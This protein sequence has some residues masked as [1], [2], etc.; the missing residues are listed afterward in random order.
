[1][2]RTQKFIIFFLVVTL[3]ANTLILSADSG[4][5]TG[6]NSPKRNLNIINVSGSEPE[7]LDPQIATSEAAIN[8]TSRI[9]EGLMKRSGKAIIPGIASRY[10][11]SEDGL[12]YTF[13]LRDAVW[14]DGK[15]V[16]AND[17]AYGWQRALDPKTVS[18]Y[19]FLMYY[20]KN[21]EKYNMGQVAQN[22]LGIK[23]I[24]EKTLQVVL[25]NPTPYFIDLTTNMTYL[26][27]RKDLV[28]IYKESYFDG[29]AH[30]VS[31]GPFKLTEWDHYNY[32]TVVKNPTYWNEK[33]VKTDIIN[34]YMYATVDDIVKAYLDGDID[35]FNISSYKGSDIPKNETLNYYTGTVFYMQFNNSDKAGILSNVNIRKALTLSINRQEFLTE[36]GTITAAPALALVAPEVI[37]GKIK[38][39]REEAGDLIK[40]NDIMTAKAALSLGLSQLKLTKMPKIN[41]IVES[42]PTAIIKADVLI[43][44]WK[45]NL[46][47]DVTVEVVSFKDKLEK[48]YNGTY[49]MALAGWGPDYYDAL[50]YLEMFDSSATLNNFGYKNIDYNNLIKSIKKET[51]KLKRIDLLQKSEKKIIDDYVVAPLYYRYNTIAYKPFIKNVSLS[52][53]DP[54]FDFTQIELVEGGKTLISS[55]SKF[56]IKV[57]PYWSKDAYDI[58]GLNGA[59]LVIID[60]IQE[61]AGTVLSFETAGEQDYLNTYYNLLTQKLQSTYTK[62]IISE[63]ANMLVSGF[64]AIKFQFST[65][66][67]G[68]EASFYYVIIS[69]PNKIY[70]VMFWTETGVFEQRI[71]EFEKIIQSISITK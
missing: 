68:I 23:V 7:S 40:D 9:M 63:K 48:M 2:N 47:I 22:Q 8:I 3:M 57:N 16:T 26:P 42:G 59:D 58:L 66:V 56:T 36:S 43:K 46:G 21:G 60:S 30:M 18:E 14:S 71:P 34:S 29:P 17:F 44:M 62:T 6:Q 20:I 24:N 39:F 5:N 33:M 45:K 19:A 54:L 35:I 51:D 10:E 61:A 31:N 41:L 55:D 13:F 37:P 65:L 28:E 27:A 1:M 25:E 32:I 11:V 4:A 50:T 52:A 38:T 70:T 53:V 12:T 64:P 69:T 49:Q 67:E 15:P